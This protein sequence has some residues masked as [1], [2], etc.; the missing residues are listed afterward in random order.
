MAS[1]KHNRFHVV[2][3][4]VFPCFELLAS[5][6]AALSSHHIRLKYRC[7]LIHHPSRKI[8]DYLYWTNN[9]FKKTPAVCEKQQKTYYA[10]DAKNVFS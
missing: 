9:V 10:P 2:L 8:E 1:R 4:V 7:P 5:W 3:D 6:Y